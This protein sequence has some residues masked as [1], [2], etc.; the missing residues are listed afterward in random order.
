M[1]HVDRYISNGVRYISNIDRT[2]T[3]DTQI[4]ANDDQYIFNDDR[5]FTLDV[6]ILANVAR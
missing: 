1:G 6:Q 3:L 2:F 5:T 4:L